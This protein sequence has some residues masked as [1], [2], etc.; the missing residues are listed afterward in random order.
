MKRLLGWHKW[1]ILFGITLALSAAAL[2]AASLY[3]Y[4]ISEYFY[5]P[6]NAFSLVGN[7]LGKW[8]GFCVMGGAFGVLLTA[9]QT[10]TRV[11][12]ALY[13]HLRSAIYAIAG[14]LVCA[15]GAVDFLETLFSSSLVV[16][17]GAIVLG[18]VVFAIVYLFERLAIRDINAYKK[19]ALV[20]VVTIAAMALLTLA[21]KWI[22]GRARYEDVIGGAAAFSPWYRLVRV[23]GDSMPSGHTMMS[24]AVLLL[25]PLMWFQRTERK[26][27]VSF[28]SVGVAMICMVAASRIM[29]GKHYLSDV[30]ISLFV[31]LTAVLVSSLVA[32]GKDLDARRF[33]QDGFWDRW[34]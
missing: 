12:S 3:D 31:G 11:P 18:G 25:A 34:L 30:A 8:V 24:C 2:I 26:L 14:V 6:D 9:S 28:L 20:T 29:A 4:K 16:Y 13:G 27:R 21:F 10:A 17:A 1:L 22:W 5:L 32:Y 7:V 19:W 15:L 23:G 33:A